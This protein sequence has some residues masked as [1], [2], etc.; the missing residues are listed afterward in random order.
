MGLNGYNVLITYWGA[1]GLYCLFSLYS[2]AV[3]FVHHSQKTY[4]NKYLGAYLLNRFFNGSMFLT[5]VFLTVVV[6][7][8]KLI[9]LM[10]GLMVYWV[11]LMV[12]GVWCGVVA[13]SRGVVSSLRAVLMLIGFML[14][15]MVFA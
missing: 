3:S 4:N 5:V 14:F 13:L 1:G 9:G 12:R 10:V 7:L 15:Y 8:L 2:F 11:G 6:C